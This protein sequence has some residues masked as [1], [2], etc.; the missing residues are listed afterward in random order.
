MACSSAWLLPILFVCFVFLEDPSAACPLSNPSLLRDLL[1][2]SNSGENSGIWDASS[3]PWDE[4]PI[5]VS[6]LEG[7][8]D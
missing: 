5:A 4:L 8:S 7:F 6:P 3:Q 2:M 1:V